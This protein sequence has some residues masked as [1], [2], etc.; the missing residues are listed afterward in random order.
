MK[1]GGWFWNPVWQK[2][3]VLGLLLFG[4]IFWVFLGKHIYSMW[5]GSAD[6]FIRPVQTISTKLE[7]WRLERARRITDLGIAQ[8]EMDALR[9]EL[10]EL[11]LERQRNSALLAEADSAINMLGLKK[12]LP[13]ELQTARIIANNRNAPFGGIIID[14][15]KNSNIEA[16]QGVICAEGVVGR[17]WAVGNEQSIVLPLD[18]HNASTSVMLARSRA[19]GVL[20]GR[21]PGVAEIRYISSQETVQIGE[22][23]YTSGLDNVFPK[24]MLIGHVSE[25]L[26]GSSVEMRI[27]VTLAAQMDTLGLLFV[28]PGA[29]QL[30]FDT[31]LER[32]P[33]A[34]RGAR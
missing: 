30:E 24:G 18:A 11:R 22:P 12:L 6:F 15:G 32:A 9:A 5:R 14:V 29:D 8:R 2:R 10:E 3:C 4:H 21:W 23:V 17:V 1:R 26:Q 27:F 25:A 20:Q 34:S 7:N 13:I 33:S 16:D 31:K 28:L 19:T